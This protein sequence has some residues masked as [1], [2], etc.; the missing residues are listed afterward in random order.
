MLIVTRRHNKVG[1]LHDLFVS[2]PRLCDNA[3]LPGHDVE[4]TNALVVAL[5]NDARGFLG[6]DVDYLNIIT[7]SR[8]ELIVMQ[9]DE[10]DGRV[11]EVESS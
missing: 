10:R 5:K 4:G 8:S 2:V 11:V 9:L 3:R 7:S 6:V 1:E